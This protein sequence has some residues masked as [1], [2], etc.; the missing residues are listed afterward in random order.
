MLEHTS[1]KRPVTDFATGFDHTDPAR[2]ANPYPSGTSCDNT[3][4]SR[5]PTA[6]AWFPSTYEGVSIVAR[7]AEYFTRRTVVVGNSHPGEDV[8][9]APIGVALYHLATHTDNLARF[10]AEPALMS[11]AVEE[12]LRFYAPATLIRLV[13]DDH[14]LLGCPIKKDDWVLLGFP[15]PTATHT[16]STELMSSSL[17][18]R[19]TCTPSSVWEYTA[20]PDRTSRD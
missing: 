14:E 16:P 15:P 10:V 20:A 3:A 12:F 9:P 1:A 5:T 6:T 7:D 13:T 17:I 8:L 11:V 2:V 18:V 19:S 4:P